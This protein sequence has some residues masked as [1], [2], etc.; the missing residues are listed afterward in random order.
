[1]FRSYKRLKFE[2]TITFFSAFFSV[3]YWNQD[4]LRCVTYSDAGENQE[5]R[6]MFPLNKN[7]TKTKTKFGEAKT[8]R[9]NKTALPYM[10]DLLN[11]EELNEKIKCNFED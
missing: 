5:M 9:L 2:K 1:M 6:K 3:T 11:T 7:Q 4:Q 10:Q 8:E